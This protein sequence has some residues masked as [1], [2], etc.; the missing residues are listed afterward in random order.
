[1][2]I[3]IKYNFIQQFF[4]LLSKKA[5]SSIK[6]NY[7]I[8]F[9][10]VT[11]NVVLLPYD[12]LANVLSSTHVTSTALQSYNIKYA[13]FGISATALI[14]LVAVVI[15]FFTSLATKMIKWVVIFISIF[16]VAYWIIA[17]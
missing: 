16:L 11:L 13:A 5:R 8:L 12:V 1:M 6:Y 7:I 4:M 9:L 17:S 10:F 15:I 3:P 14:I 2:T